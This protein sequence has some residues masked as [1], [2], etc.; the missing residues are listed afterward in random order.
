MAVS[1]ISIVSQFSSV[2][3]IA[4]QSYSAVIGS[5][6]E[7]DGMFLEVT[8]AANAL[9]AVVFFSDRDECM[10]LTTHRPDMPLSLIEW[11]IGEAKERLPAAK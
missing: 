3:E 5:D 7:R 9:V 4:G 10:T 11:M 6:V 8:D 1:D 2:I